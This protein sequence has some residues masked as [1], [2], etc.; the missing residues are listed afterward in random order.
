MIDGAGVAELVGRWWL[1]Y[2]AANFDELRDLLTDDVHFV[3]RTDSGTTDFEEFVRCD[4]EGRDPVMAWQ[5]QHRLD[6]PSPLRHMGLNVHLTGDDGADA[7]FASYLFV[8]QVVDGAVANL[9]TAVVTG[10]VREVEGALRLSAMT[11]VLDT[12]S[13]VPLRQLL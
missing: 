11:V 7:G 12:T 5:E 13:S 1:N 8:T 3:T 4:I 2:D 6:S 10:S 9:S